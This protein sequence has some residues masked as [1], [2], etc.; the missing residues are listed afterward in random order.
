MRTPRGDSWATDRLPR[1]LGAVLLAAAAAVVVVGSRRPAAQSDLPQPRLHHVHLNV[2]DPDRSVDFYTQAFP[3]TTR[4]EVAGWAAV[5]TEKVYLLFNKVATAVS[6]E[7]D[8]ALWHFGW[9][10]PDLVGDYKRLAAGGAVFFRAPPPSGHFWAPD[11]NDV[12]IAPAGPGS[13]G[14]GPRAFNHV[15]L[16]SAAPLCAARWYETTLG[17]GRMPSR[18]PAAAT[19][20]DCHVPFGPRVDPGP[21]IHE[22]NVRMRLDDLSLSI[23]PDQHPERI[24]SSSSGRVLDHIA[25]AYPDVRLALERLRAAGVTVLRD[26][27]AFGN[28]TSRAAFIEGPDKL[29]IELVEV[30]P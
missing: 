14:S 22:P 4:T 6:A 10:T 12:E 11:G 23:Y 28:S 1:A 15:H 17:L 27:H 3:T 18:T 25:L 5:Q 13:G 20:G 30:A 19:G 24:L 8:T 21:Q 26:V 29:P 16:M 9:N 2:L 7:L